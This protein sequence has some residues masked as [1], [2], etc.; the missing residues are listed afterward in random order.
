MQH[1]IMTGPTGAIGMALI[2]KCIQEQIR[3]TVICHRGSKRRAILP[4]HPLVQIIDANLDEL[5]NLDVTQIVSEDESCD[6]F[7]HLGWEGTYG[8]SRNDM[9]QQVKNIQYTLDAVE[10]AKRTGCRTFV[11]TGSQAEYGRVEGVL[12]SDTPAFPENGYGMAKLCAG[13]MSREKCKEL[14]IKHIWTRILSVYGPYDQD[15]TMI[16]STINRMLHNEPVKVTKAEQIWDYL[17]SGDVAEMLYRLSEKGIDGN[18]YCLGSGHARPLKEYIEI[19]R[20]VTKTSVIP[21]YGAIPYAPGQVM[22]LEADVTKA[23]KDTGYSNPTDF[24]ER[25]SFVVSYCREKCE[26]K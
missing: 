18:V 6:T 8:A 5:K 13:Q 3:V 20:Q 17:Y 12:R 14:K 1:I 22:H 16:M 23:I 4:I 2:Q 9:E 24:E 19:M 11:G 10:L 21:E 15:D 25:I 7:Y 26:R